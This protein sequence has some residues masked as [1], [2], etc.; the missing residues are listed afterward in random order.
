MRAQVEP[1]DAHAAGRGEQQAAEHLDG[2]GLA[3]PVRAEE[4]EQF[5]RRDVQGEVLHGDLRAVLL[6]DV[7]N[8]DHLSILAVEHEHF[9][10]L[11]Q[12]L[13]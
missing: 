7:A 9:A 5:A 1:A 13:T 12:F 8:V 10:A 2:G 4:R 11:E 6:G 3:G